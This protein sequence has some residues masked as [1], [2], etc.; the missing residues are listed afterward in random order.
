MKR[1]LVSIILSIVLLLTVGE[2]CAFA[3]NGLPK[4]V[5]VYINPLYADVLNEDNISFRRSGLLQGTRPG[6]AESREELADMIREYMDMDAV[7]AC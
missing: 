1:N 3:A 5:K 2:C 7:Y 4:G 6:V